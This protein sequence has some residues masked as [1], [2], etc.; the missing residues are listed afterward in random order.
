[1]LSHPITSRLPVCIL[2]TLDRDHMQTQPQTNSLGFLISDVSRLLRRIFQLRI[3]ESSLTYAQ[4][5]ALIYISKY[6]GVR[7]VVLAD[8]LDVQPITLARLIDHLVAEG[9][10][11]RRPDPTDRRAFQIYLCPAA[12]PHLD[13]I[14]QVS[15][16]IRQDV[17]RSLS[18]EEQ[19][20]MFGALEKMRNNLCTELKKAV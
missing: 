3:E 17:L 1:M 10:V 6:Q 20:V 7:Q 13:A 2:A 19:N 8:I 9:L 11:E 4:A 12:Q 15:D 14:Q 5:R 18:E 16:V